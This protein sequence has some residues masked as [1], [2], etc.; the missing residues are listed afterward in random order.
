M[1]LVFSHRILPVFRR[2][3]VAPR[4]D[5]HQKVGADLSELGRRRA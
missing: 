5:P 2:I 3:A 4:R 1:R